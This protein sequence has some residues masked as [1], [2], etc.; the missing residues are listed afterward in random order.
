M[1]IYSIRIKG[2]F[3]NGFLR[4]FFKLGKKYFFKRPADKGNKKAP[5]EGA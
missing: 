3:R 5:I 2:I 4:G 1:S